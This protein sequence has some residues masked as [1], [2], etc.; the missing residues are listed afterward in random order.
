MTKKKFSKKRL[1]KE[2]K[3]EKRKLK[4]SLKSFKKKFP[5]EFLKEYLNLRNMG[6]IFLIFGALFFVCSYV[7]YSYYKYKL[8]RDVPPDT[9]KIM[10]TP[11]RC[12]PP[13]VR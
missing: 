11:A 13:V 2:Y 4:K 12:A 7:A 6:I 1:I 3:K 10:Y 5:E 9:E 8:D